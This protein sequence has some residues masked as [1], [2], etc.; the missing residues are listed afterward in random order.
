MT[1]AEREL[2][3]IDPHVRFFA[4]IYVNKTAEDA[5]FRQ[6]NP[7]F[8]IGSVVIKEKLPSREPDWVDEAIAFP[9]GTP[10]HISEKDAHS[11]T[12][13]SA[14]QLADLEKHPFFDKPV[15]L[16]VMIKHGA[17]YAPTTG[18]WEFMTTD[19]QGALQQRGH[20]ETCAKCHNDSLKGSDY[21]F[22]SYYVDGEFVG[23][24]HFH[25]P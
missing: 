14:E 22:G 8:P 5:F 7:H 16:T 10:S 25:M 17:G 9:G 6:E 3:K 2:L 23:M 4:R 12:V 18:D 19:G 11:Q 20:L 24:K 15:L 21:L 1:P 13:Q